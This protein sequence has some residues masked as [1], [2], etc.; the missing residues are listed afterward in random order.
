MRG[1]P[2]NGDERVAGTSVLRGHYPSLILAGKQ[3]PAGSTH[4]R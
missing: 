4:I 3:A 1:R 2:G